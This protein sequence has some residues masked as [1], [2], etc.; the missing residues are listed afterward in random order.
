MTEF[1][2]PWQLMPPGQ[3]NRQQATHA[4][5]DVN[6]VHTSFEIGQQ[7]MVL[8]GT[9]QHS[10]RPLAQLAFTPFT[11]RLACVACFMANFVHQRFSQTFHSDNIILL[12]VP[13]YHKLTY[14]AS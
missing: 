8:T 1:K 3:L 14:C 12:V 5:L 11:S 2:S 9:A 13:F 6:G 10:H 7:N 4:I